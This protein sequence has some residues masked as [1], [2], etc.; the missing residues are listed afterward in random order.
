MKYHLIRQ[1]IIRTAESNVLLWYHI[2]SCTVH[3]EEIVT[4][5]AIREL[6][7]QNTE[8]MKETKQMIQELTEGQKET[9]RQMKETRQMIQE[10]DRRWE[11]TK[12]ELDELREISRKIERHVGNDARIIEDRKETDRR[13]EKT[14]VEI[15]ELREISR[16]I[17]RHVGND[18][19]I[20]EDHFVKA[21]ERLNLQIGD[22]VFDEIYDN[23]SRRHKLDKGMEG[24]QLDAL[25]VNGSHTGILEVKSFSTQTMFTRFSIKHFPAS[26]VCSRNIVIRTFSLWWGLLLPTRMLL[27]LPMTTASLCCYRKDRISP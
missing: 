6:F 8:Q 7:A 19:R 27:R 20:I 15:D 4:E 18:A 25:L 24:M 26:A 22:I 12:D 9:D 1:T 16:K 13:W 17:E 10:T 21:L 23:L 5:E 3:Q 2:I 14:N 11:K